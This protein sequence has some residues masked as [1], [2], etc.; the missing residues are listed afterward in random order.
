MARGAARIHSCI[1][2]VTSTSIFLK[3]GFCSTD[4]QVTETSRLPFENNAGDLLRAVA[5]SG[6]SKVPEVTLGFW[7]IKIA[8]TTLGETGGDA[9]S[10]SLNLGYAVSSVLFIGLFVV[11][12]AA[13][14][15]VRSFHPF[16]SCS[17][18]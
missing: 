8:A 17:R 13:Q 14:I 1:D 5:P 6:H 15:A 4:A 9:V 2:H 10:M 12:A 16:L 11:A 18:K 7:I 3:I